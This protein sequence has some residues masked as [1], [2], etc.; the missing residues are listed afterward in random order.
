M[1]DN[2]FKF[3][4]QVYLKTSQKRKVCLIEIDTRNMQFTIHPDLQAWVT[5]HIIMPIVANGAKK[6]A[7]IVS[8]NFLVQ[9]SVEQTMEATEA[10]F[11]TRYFNDAL[12]VRKWLLTKSS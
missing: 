10:V 7:I 2:D 3:I 6:L 9:L 4:N 5:Q 11:Q 8:A 1:S 12:T